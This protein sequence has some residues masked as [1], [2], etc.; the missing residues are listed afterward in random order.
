LRKNKRIAKVKK[1][2]RAFGQ[3][4]HG[5]IDLLL[6]LV[7]F[8]VFAIR[9]S[10]FQTW[11]AQQVAAYLSSEWGTDVTIEKVDF[12][13]FDNLDIEG[14][15]VADKINDTLLYSGLLHAKIGDWSLSKSFVTIDRVELTDATCHIKKYKGDSTFNFQH[16]VDY[17]AS[18]EPADT[19]Q[20]KLQ[21]QR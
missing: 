9:T 5:L 13:F 4:I 17:F 19:Q 20:I 6:V 7:I 18:D 10:W 1:I 2:L 15:Y 16:I 21:S 11:A 14:I 3:T 8:L 12:V